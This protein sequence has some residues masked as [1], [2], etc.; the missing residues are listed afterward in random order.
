MA[1]PT[2]APEISIRL[3]YQGGSCDVKAIELWARGRQEVRN[4]S[5]DIEGNDI[6]I[7]RI[8]ISL[9]TGFDKD[10]Q[11]YRRFY[12]GGIVVGWKTMLSRYKSIR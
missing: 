11:R 5:W 1:P 2:I 6:F 10:S 9:P 12:F 8:A 3:R 7:N 4:T